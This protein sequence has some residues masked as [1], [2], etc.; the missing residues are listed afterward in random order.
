[1]GI[2][3]ATRDAF[4]RALSDHH[5]GRGGLTLML[6][7]DD[8]SL[9]PADLQ[10][11]EFFHPVGEWPSWEQHLIDMAEGTVLDLGA[12]AG[13]HSL[14]LQ[15]LGHDLTAVDVSPGAAAVCRARGIRD[16]RLADLREFST[17]R[18]WDTVLLMCGNLG[19]AGDWVPTRVLL[20]R[21]AQMTSMGGLLIGDSV[22]PTSDDPDD[23][24]YEDRNEE[25]GF[26]RGHVRLRL[27]YDGLITPWWDQINFPPVAI[28][29]LVDGTG[30][31]LVE[32]VG[33]AEG[34]GVVLRR[35]GS[36]LVGRGYVG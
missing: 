10:P 14:Y 1:M 27:H 25:A 8:G 7:S 17:D 9:R 16:V 35:H 34:Y 13:R 15:D 29:E 33:D 18:A 2:L 24:A 23:L 5:L 26:H 32:S 6:E 12:G 4:G 21:L 19:L 31:S 11:E 30:W 36:T 28:E 20:K 3:D 22:D